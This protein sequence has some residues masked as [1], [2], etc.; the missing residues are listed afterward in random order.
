M[1]PSTF[2]PIYLDTLAHAKS[3]RI[4]EIR[5]KVASPPHLVILALEAFRLKVKLRIGELLKTSSAVR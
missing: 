4:G 1:F 2:K 3:S 5:V